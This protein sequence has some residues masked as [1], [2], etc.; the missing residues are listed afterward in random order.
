[1]TAKKRLVDRKTLDEFD[2]LLMDIIVSYQEQRFKAKLASLAD[3]CQDD[4]IKDELTELALMYQ[5][6][7]IRDSLLNLK[8]FFSD[9]IHNTDADTI[10]SFKQFL[11]AAL[12]S[13]K[14][15][16]EANKYYYD[17][18]Q[19]VKSGD[20]TIDDIMDFFSGLPS[21]SSLDN[22]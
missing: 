4:G 12:K 14:P 18:Y 3:R 22:K 7:Y 9:H 10:N 11:Y 21:L 17:L 6:Q 5:D 13:T 2:S 8:R 15:G 19:D 1:M 16:S 20:F